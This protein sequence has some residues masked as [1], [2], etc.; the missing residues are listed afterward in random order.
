MNRTL[1]IVGIVILAILAVIALSKLL[2]TVKA[3]IGRPKDSGKVLGMDFFKYSEFD[4]RAKYPEDSGKEVYTH[5]GETYLKRSGEEN[6]K[7]VFLQPLEKARFDLEQNWNKSNPLKRIVFIINSGYRTPHHNEYVGG[8]DDSAHTR[9][10]ASDI[11]W[12]GYS[13]EQKIAILKALY[14]AGFRR[15][16][17]GRNYV[18]VDNDPDKGSP[19]VWNY[20]SGYWGSTFEEIS[21]ITS[22]F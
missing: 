5:Y 6:M 8:V 11:R 10:Y 9:G 2:K 4:S 14:K 7:D 13:E 12:G 16:G 20:G 21:D 18:H 15:F 19:A 3:K 22:L 1:I 17:I